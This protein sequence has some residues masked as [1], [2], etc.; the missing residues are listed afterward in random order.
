MR[1]RFPVGRWVLPG[2]QPAHLVHYVFCY[3]SGVLAYRGDWLRRLGRAQARRWGL[4][5]LAMLPL[6]VGGGVLGGA[7]EGEAGF[8]RFLGGWHWQALGYAFWESVMCV[9]V[10]T[11]V[12]WFFRERVNRSSALLRRLAG[13]AYTVYILHQPVLI[14]AN[15]LLLRAPMPSTVKFALVALI[16]PP[17]CFALAD[18]VRRI[19]GARRVLG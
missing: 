13:S 8:A 10:L 14:A 18:V 4:V 5:A 17:L 3:A 15:I 1:I 6:F 9:A 11:Y 2:V 19:P 7:L 16:V 12:L